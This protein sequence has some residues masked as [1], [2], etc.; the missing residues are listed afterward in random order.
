M[1]TV[2][3][4]FFSAFC[5]GPFLVSA[6]PPLSRE[7]SSNQLPC[8]QLSSHVRAILSGPFL[9]LFILTTLDVACFHSRSANALYASYWLL[10][11]CAWT[12]KWDQER[13]DAR[14]LFFALLSLL[15]CLVRPGTCICT[16]M[17][18]IPVRFF[19][20]PGTLFGR[21]VV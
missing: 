20:F 7:L 19:T 16:T 21:I 9:R 6:P 14:T 10:C 15:S 5:L 2:L 8:L 17:E 18:H 1:I 12:R 3:L 11:V 13:P 4:L